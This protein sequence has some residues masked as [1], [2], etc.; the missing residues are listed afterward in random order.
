MAALP[1]SPSLPSLPLSVI[2]LLKTCWSS[3]LNPEGESKHVGERVTQLEAAVCKCGLGGSLLK[4][5][6]MWTLVSS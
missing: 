5:L 6:R 3:S 4:D 1:P 2:T